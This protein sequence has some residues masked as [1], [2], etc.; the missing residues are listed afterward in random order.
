MNWDNLTKIAARSQANLLGRKVIVSFDNGDSDLTTK[1]IVSTKEEKLKR[2]NYEVDDFSLHIS[3]LKEKIT[4]PENVIF[5][6]FD[7]NK[8]EIAK[9]NYDIDGFY[10]F[11]LKECYAK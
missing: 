6:Y 4:N 8:Y 1:G 2:S 3:I 9:Y 5:I 11:Y 10:G 7:G